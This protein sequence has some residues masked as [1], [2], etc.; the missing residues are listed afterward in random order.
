MILT[1]N[2]HGLKRY[3]EVSRCS[4]MQ[5]TFISMNQY[6]IKSEKKCDFGGFVQCNI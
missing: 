3:I 5:E 1:S 2:L 6:Q 4:S